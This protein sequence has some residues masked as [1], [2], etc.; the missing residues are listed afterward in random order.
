MFNRMLVCAVFMFPLCR[1]DAQVEMPQVR[2]SR[3]TMTLFA[4]EP[5]IVTPTGIAVDRRGRVFCIESHTH[6][7]PDDY[8]GPETDRIRIYDDTDADGRA[9]RATTFFEG[10]SATMN[11]AFAADGSL[12]VATRAKIFRLHDRNGDDKPDSNTLVIDLQTKGNYPH[13]G[14]SGLAFQNNRLYFGFGENLGLDYKLVGSDGTALSGGGEGGNVFSCAL[15]GSKL[16]A[17]ATGF[18]NPFGLA[19]DKVG[20]LIAID[21]DPDWRPPCRLLHIVEGGDY[22]YR[23]SHGRRGT[24]P[25]TAW[26]GELPGTLGMI[27]GTG[28]APSGIL[29]YDRVSPDPQTSS[30][31]CTSWGL[32]AVEKYDLVPSGASFRARSMTL[33]KGG[34]DF[35]PVG[36][37][38]APDGTVYISDWC[39]RSYELHGFGRIWKITFDDSSGQTPANNPAPVSYPYQQTD[40]VSR[41]RAANLLSPERIDFPRAFQTAVSSLEKA[42]L[43]RRSGGKPKP[44]LLTDVLSDQDPFLRQA[45]RHAL[46]ETVDSEFLTHVDLPRDPR[47]RTGLAMIMRKLSSRPE[48][49]A[50]IRWL[51]KDTDP[52]VRFVALRWIAEEKLSEFLPQLERELHSRSMTGRLFESYLAAIDM[53]GRDRPGAEYERR[54]TDLFSSILSNK[55]T[56]SDTL[57]IALR[58]LQSAQMRDSF[59]SD[60]PGLKMEL[61]QDLLSHSSTAVVREVVATLR[62]FGSPESR[63]ILMEVVR[64]KNDFSGAAKDAI[65]ALDP[66]DSQQRQQL[67]QIVCEKNGY[68]LVARQTLIDTAFSEAELE[69]VRQHDV[70]PDE[71]FRQSQRTVTRKTNRLDGI[72]QRRAAADT[73]RGRLIFFNPRFG[74]CAR[75][76][77]IDGRGGIAGPDLSNLSGMPDERLLES[78]MMPS[79]EIA[80]RHTPWLIQTSDGLVRTGVLITERGSVQTYA[81]ARGE[82]FQVKFDDIESRQQLSQSLMPEGLLD[83]MSDQEVADLLHYLQHRN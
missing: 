23:F 82:T 56:Q 1:L 27:S 76:H 31:L 18:W 30:L 68:S 10:S 73:E 51:L 43:I 14:L 36:I 22:G 61:L 5:E 25:F 13:N 20:N 72:E 28:E 6:F 9:D 50:R 38:A 64:N 32:H 78:V 52:N 33:I 47:I 59:S 44:R 26:F 48:V 62:D 7:P 2:D 11:M 79:R 54:E 71:V 3:F 53:V 80:P 57:V 34:I 45:A 35:R 46:Q 24:H 58:K 21:N 81:D 49:A 83:H 67:L 75:C 41:Q 70:D 40:V 74:K 4:Q 66:A 29:R 12:Y 17:V 39:K 60:H 37:A 42:S 63:Q 77:Q 15:D 65:I 19:F 8:A 55:Q 16:R 69:Q